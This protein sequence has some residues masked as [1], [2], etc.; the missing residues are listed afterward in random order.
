MFQSP[1]I[2]VV[3]PCV[4]MSF[5]CKKHCLAEQKTMSCHAR[6]YLSY[7]LGESRSSWAM[8]FPDSNEIGLYALSKSRSSWVMSFPDSNENALKTPLHHQKMKGHVRQSPLL[9]CITTAAYRSASCSSRLYRAVRR[10]FRAPRFCL[11][12]L[13]ISHR[14]S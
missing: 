10:V 4:F 12:V 2:R 14:R 9:P 1:R 8:S 13:R 3:S 11:R 7:A 5:Q 6:G